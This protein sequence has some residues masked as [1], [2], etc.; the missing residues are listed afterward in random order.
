MIFPK[1][2]SSV[3]TFQLEASPLVPSEQLELCSGST[4]SAGG[5]WT[6]AIFSFLPQRDLGKHLLANALCVPWG[7]CKRGRNSPISKS[8]TLYF[9]TQWCEIWLGIISF[10][11]TRQTVLGT[12]WALKGKM[13][14]DHADRSWSNLFREVICFLIWLNKGVLAVWG[15]RC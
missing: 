7:Q 13:E 11:Y 12:S 9:T 4:Q 2:L 8:S 5:S 6:N 14:L 1:V 10:F 15:T 3:S